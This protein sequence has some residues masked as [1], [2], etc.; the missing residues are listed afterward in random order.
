MFKHRETSSHKKYI[1]AFAWMAFCTFCFALVVPTINY[2]A[3]AIAHFFVGSKKIVYNESLQ[4]EA[5]CH[6]GAR[7]F[8]GT[9][10]DS[11]PKGRSVLI[12]DT[13]TPNISTDTLYAFSPTDDVYVGKV[14]AEFNTFFLQP[15]F[16]SDLP[17]NAYTQNNTL[18]SVTGKNE[19]TLTSEIPKLAEV[20]LGEKITAL[21]AG[22]MKFIGT[23]VAIHDTPQSP[24]KKIIIRSSLSPQSLQVVCVVSL[25]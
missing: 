20:S 2:T 14:V 4:K 23:I 16:A 6:V 17:F 12:F 13:D 11:N 5:L 18:I 10:L 22:H 24:T 1:F 9:P 3:N 7:A 19:T 8:I 21:I 25:P 15:L